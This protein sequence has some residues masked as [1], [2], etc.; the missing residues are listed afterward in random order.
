MEGDNQKC[1]EAGCDDYMTKPLD[2]RILVEKI[3]KFLSPINDA[4]SEK[5]NS[6]K[7]QANELAKLYSEPVAQESNLKEA[8]G[9]EDNKEILN[10]DELIGR[11][12]DEELI[13][14]IVPIFLK[15]NRERLEMLTEAIKTGDA[16]AV[17][18]YA[19]AVKGAGRNIGAKQLSDTAHRLECAGREGDIEA[20][21]SLFDMLKVELEKVMTFLSQSDWIEVAKREKIITDEKLN[22]NSA[23]Y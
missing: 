15:D 9:I 22:A 21:V 14:E 2:R 6:V 4:L 18:L 13:R 11:L 19:H 3:R 10:W 7:A 17:K 16:K 8:A 23:C 1:I 20:A 12:G 5:A